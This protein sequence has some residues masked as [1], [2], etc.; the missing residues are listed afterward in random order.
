[1]CAASKYSAEEVEKSRRTSQRKTALR[2]IV[3][4][5]V[6]FSPVWISANK[7]LERTEFLRLFVAYRMATGMLSSN[8]HAKDDKAHSST[9]LF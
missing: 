9:Q 1:M 8:A 6:P 7:P 2:E 5:L 3:Y 4:L